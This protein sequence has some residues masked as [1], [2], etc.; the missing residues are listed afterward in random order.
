[1]I[2]NLRTRLGLYVPQDTADELGG[3]QTHWVF[4]RAFWAQVTPKSISRVSENGRL[5]ITQA[6][7]VTL[8]YRA[9][10]PER[11]QIIWGHRILRVITHSDPDN[12][13]ERLHVMC[14]EEQR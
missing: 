13:Q 6:Y 7:Q 3:V 4:L 5:A 12:R 2:G 1:M 9:D 8:R 14:E 11:A 10:F